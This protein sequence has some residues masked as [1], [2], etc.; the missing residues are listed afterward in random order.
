M[1]RE[2]LGVPVPPSRAVPRGYLSTLS[3]FPQALNSADRPL[4]LYAVP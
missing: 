4:P 3:C 1:S 2:P